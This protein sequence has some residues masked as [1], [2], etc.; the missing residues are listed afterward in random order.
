MINWGIIGLGNVAYSFAESF[1]NTKNSKLLAVASKNKEKLKKFTSNFK[2]KADYSLSDY[3][4]VLNLKEIDIVYIA[5]PNSHHYEW[6]KKSLQNEKN[7]LVEKPATINL[8][9]IEDIK[10]LLKKKS[11]IFFSEGYMYK[12]YPQTNF[13]LDLIKNDEIGEIES[14]ISSFGI[15]LLTKKKFFIFKKKKKIDLYDRR[16]NKD[17]GGGCI[18]DLGCYPLSMSTLVNSIIQSSN[19]ENIQLYNTKKTFGETKVEIDAST[20]IVFNNKFRSKIYSSFEKNLDNDTIIYGK[21]G[22]IQL[23]NSWFGGDIFLNK[24]NNNKLI[25]F[26][27]LN[28]IYSYQIEKISNFLSNGLKKDSFPFTNAEESVRNMK[29]IQKWINE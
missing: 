17:L 4:E 1:K 3:N 23:R 12:Y 24:N 2:I 9:E 15:N 29:L 21:K 14:L 20:E 5:L 18:L 8:T 6:I 25:K 28:T 13:L 27:N 19:L 16:F 26:D 22:F 7:I 10:N 11:Q